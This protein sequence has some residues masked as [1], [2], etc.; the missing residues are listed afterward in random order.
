MRLSVRTDFCT[1]S[2]LKRNSISYVFFFSFPFCSNIF[3]SRFFVCRFSVASART[4][5]VRCLSLSFDSSKLTSRAW[6]V[7]SLSG[8]L[9]VANWNCQNNDVTTVNNTRKTKTNRCR[10]RDSVE[11]N[12]FL[13]R[14]AWKPLESFVYMRESKPLWAAVLALGLEIATNSTHVL[15]R[16][17]LQFVHLVKFK[18]GGSAGGGGFLTPV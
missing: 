11:E 6:E 17:P 4:S 7:R 9:S 10:P 14:A 12:P 8:H 3:F 1:P 13:A 16:P 5:Q 15:W 2:D 18:C